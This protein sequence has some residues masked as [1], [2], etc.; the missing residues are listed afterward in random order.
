MLVDLQNLSFRNPR[1]FVVLD[2]VNGAGKGTLMQS[3]CA[4]LS[5][6]KVSFISTFEPGATPLG[7]NLRKILLESK[8]EKP[9][10]EAELFLFA[11]DRRQHVAQV[12]EPALQKNVLVI[13]DRYYYSTTA[14]QGYGRKLDLEKVEKVNELAHSG[15]KPD[16]VILLDLDPREGLKRTKKRNS[17]CAEI[18][19]DSFEKEE[20]AFHERLR[21]G[22]LEMA[23]SYSEPFLMINAALPREQVFETAKAALNALLNALK[24][25]E[26]S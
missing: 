8:E 23:K 3:L 16:L 2:G 11:A 9:C 26:H 5:D 22:F 10:P 12:I 18:S 4:Y 17:S 19:E 21:C 25:K 20:I 24:A 1:G 6:N 7:K 15:T 13:S 14:F